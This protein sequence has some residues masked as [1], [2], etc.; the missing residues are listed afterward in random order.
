MRRWLEPLVLLSNHW[1]SLSG[2][3]LVTTA[4]VLSILLLPAL[5]SGKASNPYLG[6][7]TFLFLPILFFAGL[8]LIPAGMLLN[9]RRGA[10]AVPE[11]LTLQTP[12]V[13]RLLTFVAFTTVVNLLLGSQLT[14]RAVA[15][16]D[17]P[18][19]CGATC[20]VMQPQAVAHQNA[21][22]ANVE[23]VKCHIGP[24][25][26]GYVHAKLNGALQL[27]SLVAGKYGRPIIAA[28]GKIP[29]A[30]DTC[31]SCHDPSKQYGDRLRVLTK[32][33]EDEKSAQAMT[34]LLMHVGGPAAGIHGAHFGA[35][36]SIRYAYTDD[37][38]QKIPW[39]EVRKGGATTAF[40]EQGAK[41]GVET[42]LRIK[43]MDCQDCHNRPA[44]TFESPDRAVDKA[45][46]RGEISPSLPFAKKRALEVLKAAY[47]SREEAAAKIPAAYLAFFPQQPSAAQSAK[48][49][50]EIWER[51][52]FPAMKVAWGSYPNQ[53]G[54]TDSPGCFRCHDE[55]HVAAGDK[56]ITQDCNACHNMVAVE[57]AAPK[58][59][60]DLGMQVAKPAAPAPK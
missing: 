18:E 47:A 32:Y 16:M 8:I 57:D 27:V 25:A 51:N 10:A 43:T 35:G 2:V 5:L 48:A 41:P 20:H 15:Y 17:T 53:L 34:V 33:G 12:A 4:G 21:S 45:I 29:P 26:Q 28:P 30:R 22:H 46:A 13:R 39:I 14:Y 49:V 31:D 11:H 37:T 52:V 58:V 56:K 44:H 24:G 3:V 7:L 59:L 1:L 19:F 54:H 38:L 60:T 55:A 6:I 23:C 40:L 42:A 9:R 36:T 50:R